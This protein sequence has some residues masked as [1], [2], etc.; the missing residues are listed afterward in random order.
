MQLSISK[1]LR[2]YFLYVCILFCFY[3]CT[4]AQVYSFGKYEEYIIVAADDLQKEDLRW[5]TYLF[6][7]LNKRTSVSGIVSSEKREGKRTIEIIIQLDD[8]LKVD[9]KI[10]N[11]E[12]RL[13]LITKGSREMLWLIYQLI[14]KIGEEDTRIAAADLPPTLLSFQDVEANFAFKYRCVY[15]PSNRN[16][17]LLPIMAS[18]N[19]DYDWGL[20]GHN[21]HK[22]IGDKGDETLYSWTQGERNY[23]QYCFSSANLFRIIEGYIIDYFSGEDSVKISIMPNDNNLVC[24]CDNCIA[25][26]NKPNSATAAVSNLIVKLANRFPNHSFYTSAYLT[27]NKPPKMKMPSNVGV[28]ISAME[29]PMQIGVENSPFKTKF[30]ENVDSWKQSVSKIYIW[31]YIRNFDDY[32][33]PYP[34][35]GIVKERLLF[36]EQMGVEGVI[37]N[38]SGY[39][40]ALFDDLQTYLLQ[41]ML[42]NPHVD[43][44]T[45]CTSYLKRGYPVSHS[46]L[47]YYYALLE[48]RIQQ[49]KIELPYYGGIETAVKNYLYPN[50]FDEFHTALDKLS[51]NI[52]GE[53]RKKLNKMLTAMQFTR[54]EF[55]RIPAQT[56][57][58]D[59]VHTVTELLRGHRAFPEMENYK[60]QGGK[61]D[62]Y[63]TQ[64]I[65]IGIVSN[66]KNLLSGKKLYLVSPRNEEL[67]QLSDGYY[68][69][70]IDYHQGW[71]ITSDTLF[72]ISIPALDTPLRY[73]VRIGVMQ[74]KLWN[75]CIPD[76]IE[77]WSNGDILTKFELDRAIKEEDASRIM[78][79]TSFLL[80]DGA[81]NIELRIINSSKPLSKVVLD[82]IEIYPIK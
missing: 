47:D 82:E 2:S 78:L 49:K 80:K 30:K 1:G 11:K 5:A 46:L 29:L 60:E 4:Q 52:A 41:S 34:M 3:G 18:N 20:W 69:L 54:L 66:K 22:V 63:I 76:C 56:Y 27:T 72:S 17:D 19:I 37:L 43:I 74:S 67:A 57:N 7:Q 53:E 8:K 32:L 25:L 48:D 51:K 26:G 39:D 61:I 62:D 31:D 16:E 40:Y 70:P 58:K 14:S 28:V 12:G 9:Y 24:Q 65:N 68:G 33:S 75:H 13:L 59:N 55:M 77:V 15:T 44:K 81:N 23:S 10:V 50:E 73:K 79:E 38:G 45:L 71:Y 36:Y 64:Y 6:D 35:L 21:L 42:I